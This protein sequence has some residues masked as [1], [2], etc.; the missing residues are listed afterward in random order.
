MIRSLAFVLA[1]C[2]LAEAYYVPG[3]YPQEFPV[4]HTLKV[5][6]N[7]LTSFETDLP[8]NY[9]SLPFCRPPGGPRRVANAANLGT[10]LQGLRIQTSPY[11]LKIMVKELG[12]NACGEGGAAPA[13]TAEQAEAFM[14][15]V[16]KRYRVNLVLDNLPVTVYDLQGENEFVRPGFELGYED[17]GAYYV[18][19]HLRFNILVHPTHGDN[20]RADDGYGADA[21]AGGPEQLYMI[22]GFE[23]QPCSIR[24]DP[25]RPVD[26]V[27]CSADSGP[28][29]QEIKEGAAI[30]YTYD[31]F[32]QVSQTRWASRWDA[33]LRMPGGR[34]H[35]F[36]LLNSLLIVLVMASL[37]G[38]TLIRTVRR[39]LSRL[40]ALIADEPGDPREEAGWKLL[41]GDV[42]RA[43]PDA[44]A[45]CV[46]FGSGVQILGC[47]LVTL[48]LATM[49]FLSPA[50]RGA[51]LTATVFTYV[52]MSALAGAAAVWLWGQIQ[53]SHDGWVR[54][55]LHVG[56]FYPG[57][58]MLIFT[59]L[60]IFI[61]HTGSTGAVP[62][63]I[64]FAIVAIWLFI[65]APLALVGGYLGARSRVI[66]HPTKTN[67]IARQVPAPQ[68]A[69]HPLVLFFAAGVLP[70]GTLFVE[71]YFAMT[72][73]WLGF[74][75]YL[76]FF[77]LAVG[78]LAALINAEI[79][80]LCTYVQL[81]AED[82]AWWW[83]SFRR[84]GSVALYV[85]A[86][87]VGFLSSTLR[88][89]SGFLPVLVYVS[90]MSIFVSGLYFAM[91]AVGFAASGA[92]VYYIM[93]AGKAD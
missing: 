85:A 90:Y 72:S 45:L 47:A 53:R 34:V 65:S 32:W 89:L 48:V 62:V 13:L 3:T 63:G 7:S 73:V 23:V 37:V 11:D 9:Y 74:F 50:S 31:V 36:S 67:Q 91:G 81:C 93:A 61:K 14:S 24:R 59:V 40:E 5:A 43:P 26:S 4:G 25:G 21:S 38:A 52:V 87:S 71:L 18:H 79:A 82:H 16:D 75:Y 20:T 6:V 41:T 51:L 12:K 58:L 49:G 70:F 68:L 2:A 39:D 1:L 22:V 17:G 80:V 35:W 86:Y 83:P 76:F 30:V 44:R 54:V 33:Y 77:V 64:Y 69:A 56:L 27:D 8:Y 10:I 57:I 55:A 78:A 46:Y 88:Q 19:N 60:N 42:F 84:G 92:F 66:D 28:P 15:R 29:P